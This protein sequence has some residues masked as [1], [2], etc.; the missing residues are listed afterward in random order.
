MLCS[1]YLQKN[2]SMKFP[3]VSFQIFHPNSVY[4]SKY[5]WKR[6]KQEEAEIK[7]EK[8]TITKLFP[9]FLIGAYWK[10]RP[11]AGLARLSKK[12]EK[13]KIGAQST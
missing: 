9:G 13:K 2:S 4:D 3:T 11:V 12:K 5:A 7:E 10:A 6:T 8:H 1:R